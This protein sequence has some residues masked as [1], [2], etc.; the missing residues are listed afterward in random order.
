M[1]LKF[2]PVLVA[3]FVLRLVIQPQRIVL[4]QLD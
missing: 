2:K 1:Q 3:G 4:L